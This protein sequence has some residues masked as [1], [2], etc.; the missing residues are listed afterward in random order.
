MGLGSMGTW[1]CGI[2]LWVGA[3]RE[4]GVSILGEGEPSHSRAGTG[5]WA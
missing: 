1:G 4:A 3:H 5:P 2:V